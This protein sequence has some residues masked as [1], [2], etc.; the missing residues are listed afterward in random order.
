GRVVVTGARQVANLRDP[1]PGGPVPQQDA[2]VTNPGRFVAAPTLAIAARSLDPDPDRRRRTHPR[3]EGMDHA[4]GRS[5]ML[6]GVWRDPQGMCSRS[7]HLCSQTG[8]LLRISA[9]LP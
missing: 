9:G 1:M 3:V 5:T 6:G 8:P 2:K 7:A 4:C